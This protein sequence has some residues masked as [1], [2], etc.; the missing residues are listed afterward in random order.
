M[1]LLEIIIQLFL[2]LLHKLLDIILEIIAQ[3]FNH[4]AE[5]V[6]PTEIPTKEAKAE[7][8]THSVTTEDKIN[9]FS[10]YIVQGLTNLFVLVTHQFTVSLFLQSINVL[11]HL[12]FL[13]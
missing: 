10:I 4:T 12:C 6:M 11:F 1:P 3:V 8:K 7:T 5:F 2:K 13:I 9:K